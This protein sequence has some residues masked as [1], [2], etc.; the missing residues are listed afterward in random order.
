M[1]LQYIDLPI[2]RRHPV[3]PPVHLA[4]ASVALLTYYGD[5]QTRCGLKSIVLYGWEI[6][7]GG[8]SANPE[9]AT[10]VTK[11][12]GVVHRETFSRE[13]IAAFVEDPRAV[14]PAKHRLYSL[15]VCVAEAS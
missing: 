12:R 5:L 13:E 1:Y 11:V 15:A 2:P 4:R 3:N 14:T 10:L 9:R 8:W 7:P 6:P